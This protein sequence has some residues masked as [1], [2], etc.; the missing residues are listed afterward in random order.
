MGINNGKEGK[1]SQDTTTSLEHRCKTQSSCMEWAEGTELNNSNINPLF[2]PNGKRSKGKDVNI[3]SQGMWVIP[4]QQHP[5]CSLFQPGPDW[6]SPLPWDIWHLQHPLTMLLLIP[7]AIPTQQGH[8]DYF[9]T[10]FLK[11]FPTSSRVPCTH[12]CLE[13]QDIWLWR[14]EECISE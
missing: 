3:S 13:G 2:C 1:W 7:L 11:D 6:H 4:G 9:A 5:P 10:T 12:W 8:L 14:V